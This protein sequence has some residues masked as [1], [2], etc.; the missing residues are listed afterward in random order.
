MA[1]FIRRLS[2]LALVG[3]LLAA[4]LWR[5]GSQNNVLAQGTAPAAPAAT[6][7]AQA[8][9]NPPATK[10]VVN[11][12]LNGAPVQGLAASSCWPPSD[13]S[14]ALCD[15]NQDPQPTTPI[16]VNEGDNLVFTVDPASPP[17]SAL[18][19][20][21]LDDKDADGQKRP[22]IDLMKI[23]GIFVVTGLNAT[24]TNHRLVVTASYPPDSQGDQL[25]VDYA[26]LLV[27]SP[28]GPATAAAGGPSGGAT[29]A[30]SDTPPA[31][32]PATVAA[33]QALAGPTQEVAVASPTLEIAATQVE[34]ATQPV[35]VTATP[36]GLSPETAVPTTPVATLVPPVLPSATP[37]PL[38]TLAQPTAEQLNP[39]PIPALPQGGST[40]PTTGQGNVQLIPGVSVP[41]TVLIVEGRAFDAIAVNSCVQG[42]QGETVCVN[43]PTDTTSIAAFG[44]AGDV[45]QI[46][47]K[48]PRPTAVT[49]TLFSSDGTTVINK[50]TLQADNLVLY[51]LPSAAGDFVLNV[52]IVYPGGSATYYFRLNLTS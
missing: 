39:T 4:G 36:S 9:G 31:L 48:G 15:L 37:L 17:P 7:A 38:P 21:L 10:P 14:A 12:S 11:G 30:P 47:F 23:G 51:S 29:V 40:G 49:V 24:I 3:I 35:V 50:Q 6:Q 8:P 20:T 5:G 42:T 46:N 1:I 22:S 16:N 18:I 33:T 26:F 19:G 44:V 28:S 25:Y 2:L 43:H 27:T 32:L 13:P 34:L 45:A 41:A 52:D